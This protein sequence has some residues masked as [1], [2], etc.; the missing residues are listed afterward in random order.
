MEEEGPWLE[1]D[2]EE[3][4]VFEVVQVMNGDKA[5]DPMI[6]LWVLLNHVGKFL[7]EDIMTVFR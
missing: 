7:K 3:R 4:E 5:P 2:F 1:R 6:F